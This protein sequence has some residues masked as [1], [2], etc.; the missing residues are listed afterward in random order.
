M[1]LTSRGSDSYFKKKLLDSVQI[2]DLRMKEDMNIY[3]RKV[4][5]EIEGSCKVG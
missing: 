2:L 1:L 5:D 4:L 3:V